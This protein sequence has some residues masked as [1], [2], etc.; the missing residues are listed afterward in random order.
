MKTEKKCWKIVN[1]ELL[2]DLFEVI[3]HIEHEVKHTDEADA[4][5]QF[6]KKKKKNICF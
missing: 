6:N 5:Q 3:Q 2:D 4:L 1:N